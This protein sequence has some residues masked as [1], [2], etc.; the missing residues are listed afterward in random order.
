MP[1]INGIPY[2]ESGDFVSAYPTVSQDLAQ[3]VSDQL[4]TK[5]P[6]SYGTATPSTTTDGFL[7]Y[8]ENDTPP[9]PKFWDGA[10]FQ[11]VAAPSGMALITSESFSAVSSV[12]INGCF[13]SNYE[14]YAIILRALG[15]TE[16]TGRIRLRAS[17]TDNTTASAYVIQAV[18]GIT[19]SATAFNNVNNLWDGIFYG[20]A[21]AAVA[22]YQFY[23]PAVAATTFF[24]GSFFGRTDYT[25]C[26]GGY[27]TQATAYDGFTLIASTGTFTGVVKIYGY[28]D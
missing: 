11:N 25:A 24:T 17:G 28:K 7:W 2:V 6:Y 15:S 10:A 21:T 3:E 22:Q 19:S 26:V 8:D 12:P 20:D 4:A 27:H 18:R 5:L 13:T 16:Y 1:D 14:N 9:T 23:R